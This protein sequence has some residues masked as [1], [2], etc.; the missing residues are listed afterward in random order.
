MSESEFTD[1]LKFISADTET[2]TDNGFSMAVTLH[3]GDAIT[4]IGRF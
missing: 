3:N 1:T 2:Y 4:K